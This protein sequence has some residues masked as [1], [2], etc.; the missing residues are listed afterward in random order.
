MSNTTNAATSLLGFRS[1][2]ES[3]YSQGL[4]TAV[5]KDEFI[6]K[7]LQK[8][9]YDNWRK[10]CAALL[11]VVGDHVAA[12]RNNTAS[13]KGSLIPRPIYEAYKKCLS[14]L[15]L[16][17]SETRL[18]VG[19]NDFETLLTLVTKTGKVREVSEITFR[20]EFEKFIYGR[21]TG[22]CVLTRAEYNAK[23]EA[24]RKAKAEERKAKK[25]AEKEAQAAAETSTTETVKT[26][27]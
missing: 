9:N 7:G 1:I 12:C 20:K 5:S 19:R 10:D 15:E 11:L 16:G 21:L 24:E 8:V 18:K 23:K 6:A 25:A 13:E 2:L 17:E 27:A 3:H 22:E 26:A 14:Y 4:T